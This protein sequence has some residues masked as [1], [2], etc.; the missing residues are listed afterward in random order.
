MMN[1]KHSPL[2]KSTFDYAI[3]QNILSGE[4]LANFVVDGL[5]EG[6]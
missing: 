5:D 3:D 4:D 6:N 1:R 2:A